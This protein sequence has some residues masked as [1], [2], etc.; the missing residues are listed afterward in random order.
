MIMKRHRNLLSRLANLFR[1]KDLKPEAVKLT[2]G[3]GERLA[4][5]RGIEPLEGRI[6]PASLI[7]AHTV[8][9]ND[10]DGDVV[11]V[12]VSKALFDPAAST[13]VNKLDQIFTFTNGTTASLFD[14]SGPQQL[15]L[16]DLTK[17]S[18]DLNTFIS[19]ADGTSISITAAKVGASD[20]L[21]NVGAI[22]ATNIALGKVSVDGDLGQID[23][24]RAKIPKGLQSLVVNSM[25]KSGVSTQPA[26]VTAADALE[27]RITGELG[28]L[29]VKTD[30]YGFIHAVDGTSLVSGN[31][32]TTAPAKITSVTING[33]VIGN[34]TV[35]TAS[36]NTGLIDSD[37]SIGTVRIL[38]VGDTAGLIG[39]GGTNSGA[40]LANKAIASVTIADSII[41]G[42]GASSGA[43]ISKRN[44]VAISVGDDVTG[45]AGAGSGV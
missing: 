42:G 35:G 31:V 18:V 45:G 7:D 30:F 36:N 10:L 21:T 38:G 37:G 44:L 33:S 19:D 24:G 5:I 25:Y 43:V 1:R 12:T 32:Q 23:C 40:I 39:G 17:V 13:T 41:G 4:K 16:L 22:K 28:S 9:Y 14:D 2:G 34:A 6:A 8:Q 26:T 20:D 15:Q 29:R 11:T 3:R 27:S